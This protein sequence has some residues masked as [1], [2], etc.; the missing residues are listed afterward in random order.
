M[1]GDTGAFEEFSRVVFG[2]S[3]FYAGTPET[4]SR[5]MHERLS[6]GFNTLSTQTGSADTFSFTRT[7]IV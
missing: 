6:N 5:N 3:F 4:F 2:I 7:A 1:H